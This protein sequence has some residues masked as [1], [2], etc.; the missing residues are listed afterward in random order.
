MRTK[1]WLDAGFAVPVVFFFT[2]FL[3]GLVQGSYDH[4]S[5]LVSELGTIG[6]KSQY[7]F[8]A[9]LILS[10]LLSVIFIVGLLGACRRLRLSAWPV[11]PIFSFSISMAGAAIFPLPLRMHLIMGSPVL[12]F[13]LSPLL[14]LLL[15]PQKH[16][17]PCVVEMSVPSLLIMALGLLAYFPDVLASYP[18]LKQRF[19]HVG[20]SVWFVY[21]STAFRRALANPPIKA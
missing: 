11:L 15:W 3:C 18:G 2:T 20:W 8:A 12:L 13:L 21:L 16:R 7:L 1:H 9:G 14:G 10:S 5:R 6:T 19:F 17:L 4:L